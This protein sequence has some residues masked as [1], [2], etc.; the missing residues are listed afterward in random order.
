[1]ASEVTTN[2]LL[3]DRGA[4]LVKAQPYPPC[5]GEAGLQ[6]FSLSGGRTVLQVAFTQWTGMA[7]IASY[8]RPA[9]APD[10]PKASDALRRAVC[11]S[12]MGG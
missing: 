5:P 7:V 3:R 10:D 6:T 8:K 4:K 1:M 11:S 12:P 2:T 9:S